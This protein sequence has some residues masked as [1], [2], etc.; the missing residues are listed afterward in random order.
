MS[1]PALAAIDARIAAWSTRWFTRPVGRQQS[2]PPASVT[3]SPAARHGWRRFGPG[4][5]LDWGDPVA[6]ML[7]LHAIGSG[8]GRT[9]LQPPPTAANLPG[10]NLTAED[11]RLLASLGECLARDLAASLSVARPAAPAASRAPAPTPTTT[12][13]TA[14]P[15]DPEPA[16][17]PGKAIV[18]RLGR[19]TPASSLAV[20]IDAALMATLRRQQCPAWHPREARPRSLG[21]AVGSL[22]VDFAVALGGVRIG[23]LEFE[24]IERGETIV[25]DQPVGLPIPLRAVTTGAAIRTAKLVR[26]DGQ[27]LLTAS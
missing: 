27:L 19:A 26:E 1:A 22:A 15:A 5:W 9:E 20:A 17:R 14:S 6:Q 23:L 3:L 25:L 4:V 24:A 13:A 2:G 21:E 7:A 12:T 18:F 11:Q 8:G 10:S 16:A